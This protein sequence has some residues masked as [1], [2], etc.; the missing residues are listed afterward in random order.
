MW[1]EIGIS[2]LLSFIV[3]IVFHLEFKCKITLII[4]GHLII[5]LIFWGGLTLYTPIYRAFLIF[6]SI[7]LI[8]NIGINIL[9]FKGYLNKLKD[10]ILNLLIIDNVEMLKKRNLNFRILIYSLA[11]PFSVIAYLTHKMEDINNVFTTVIIIDVLIDLILSRSI[12]NY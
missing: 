12:N 10:K 8:V 3:S 6:I 11:L 5:L 7:Y 4:I 9:S 1:S 2:I